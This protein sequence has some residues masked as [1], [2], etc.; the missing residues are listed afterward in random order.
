MVLGALV[1]AL[2][3]A[4]HR[5]SPSCESGL[6]PSGFVCNPGTSL[7]EEAAKSQ[8]TAQGLL[9]QP[10]VV[11][12]AD[13]ALGIAA[14]DAEHKSLVWLHGA[15]NAWEVSSVA[16][17]LVDPAEL[18]TGQGVAAAVGQDGLV[19]LAWRR[20]ADATLWYAVS[21]E[22]GWTREQVTVAPSGTVGG[23]VALGLWQGQPVLA[24]RATDLPGV[25][26]GWRDADGW[27]SD[28]LPSAVPLAGESTA[29]ADVGRYLALAVLPTGPAI[30]AYDA[31][32][33]GLV[34][35]VHTGELGVG[36]GNWK[37]S[38]I[39][40]TDPGMA[41]A[42]GDFGAPLAMALGPGGEPVLAYRDRTHNRVLL[43]RSKAGVL[44]RQVVLT[45]DR[46]DA[47]LQVE[48]TDLLGT[49]LSVRVTPSGLAVV[50][51]QNGSTM[52]IHVAAEQTSGGFVP[53]I[54]PGGIA[55]WPALATR[56]DGS[57]TCLWLDLSDPARHGVGR[58]RAWPV[59]RGTP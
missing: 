4:C 42:D 10:A 2:L 9:G 50:A 34:L 13:N 53:Y 28:V 48:R 1:L 52:R 40:G 30:A 23:A 3:P 38:R 36:V 58:L 56:V 37:V 27:Q 5:E 18:P 33:R 19:H 32:H 20:S 39:A 51:A 17:P 54:I 35:A 15:D 16:G 59:P 25:R 55:G 31:T 8:P 57:V 21:S 44:T 24:W 29:A 7:C 43:A 26:V 12:L 6:C 49:A 46:V 41:E 14:F 22:Q 11:P 47:A 45:G